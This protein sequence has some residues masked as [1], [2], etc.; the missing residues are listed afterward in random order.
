MYPPA[1][2]SSLALLPSRSHPLKCGAIPRRP[3]LIRATSEIASD[4]S[5]S[6]PREK[7]PDRW[8]P[9][10]VARIIPN[11]YSFSRPHTIYGTTISILSLTILACITTATTPV[12][13]LISL[14]TTLPPAWLLNVYIVG[15]N[16]LYDRDIDAVNKP[17][18]PLP[19]GK[20][21]TSDAVVTIL[22]CCV[23]GLS[24]CLVPQATRALRYVL[25]GSVMLGTLYS[26]P[27]FRLKRFALLASIAILSVRGALV[28]I[29]FFLHV[30]RGAFVPPILRFATL[31]FTMFGIVIAL[32]KDVPDIHGD[33]LYGIRTFSVR[34]GARTVFNVCVRTLMGM[35]LVA[36]LY[37]MKGG[38]LATIVGLV[39]LG[40]A[41]FVWKRSRSVSEEGEEVFKYYMMI[42]KLFYLEYGL[43]LLAAL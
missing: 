33:R 3:I 35:Y 36:G 29:C 30:T 18:L 43:L 40:L 12:Q 6:A 8:V 31:F 17:Y 15:L 41:W 22:M 13:A 7:L 2:V 5:R 25:A 4:P 16:Q 9:P 1:F 10:S 37:Y 34:L 20:M 42:W 39:H 19:S 14:V 23:L 28:N 38:T 27:P 32:L 21:T 24:F 26:M 11:L